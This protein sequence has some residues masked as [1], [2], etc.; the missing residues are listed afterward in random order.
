LNLELLSSVALPAVKLASQSTGK[1]AAEQLT[2]AQHTCCFEAAY[3]SWLVL[4][5]LATSS[6]WQAHINTLLQETVQQQGSLPSL[7]THVA[8]QP[9]LDT[10][11]LIAD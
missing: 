9:I 8:E 10:C 5:L 11:W 3:S 6:S 4:H 1:A 7:C 2:T